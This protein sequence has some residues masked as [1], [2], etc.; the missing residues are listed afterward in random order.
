MNFL[1]QLEHTFHYNKHSISKER[2]KKIHDFDRLKIPVV[3]RLVGAGIL[4][5]LAKVS[6]AKN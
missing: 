3:K 6:M 4:C 5:W 2:N 1:K